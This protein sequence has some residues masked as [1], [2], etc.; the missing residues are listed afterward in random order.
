M[1]WAIEGYMGMTDAKV[2]VCN[3]QLLDESDIDLVRSKDDGEING[4]VYLRILFEHD[5][6]NGWTIRT[7]FFSCAYGG[8]SGHCGRMVRR[9]RMPMIHLFMDLLM[10]PNASLMNRSKRFI[11]YRFYTLIRHGRLSAGDRRRIC[12]CVS[13]E[14]EEMFPRP[15]GV[16]GVGFRP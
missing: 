8:C 4:D 9:Y 12:R 5:A 13:M 7:T 14:I 6:E 15:V 11:C 10:P 1:E 2:E 3:Q 16:R